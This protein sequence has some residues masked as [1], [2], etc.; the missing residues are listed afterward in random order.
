MES[1]GLA[2]GAAMS[3]RN[4]IEPSAILAADGTRVRGRREPTKVTGAVPRLLPA[5]ARAVTAGP[6]LTAS[7]VVVAAATAARVA[8]M[9]RRLA[10][11]AAQ[12]ALGGARTRELPDGLEISWTRVEVRWPPGSRW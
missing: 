6:F 5:L 7:T 2:D 9:A 11:E 4:P 1:G 10:W 3:T 12:G 8:E